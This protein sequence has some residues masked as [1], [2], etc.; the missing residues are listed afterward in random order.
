MTSGICPTALHSIAL[1]ETQRE[2]ERETGKKKREGGRERER[3]RAATVSGS[4][5]E[6]TDS[7]LDIARSAHA[8]PQCLPLQGTLYPD[9]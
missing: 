5:K 4:R 8:K 6:V 9:C 3:E 2:R 1:R 7:M